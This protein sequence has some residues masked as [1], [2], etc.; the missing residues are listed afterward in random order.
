MHKML[1]IRFLEPKK[2]LL[3]RTGSENVSTDGCLICLSQARCV[4]AVKAGI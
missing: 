2:K 3:E 1:E 4:A